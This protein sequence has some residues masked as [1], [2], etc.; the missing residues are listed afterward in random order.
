MQTRSW[1]GWQSA[2]AFCAEADGAAPMAAN[3]MI[4]SDPALARLI[5]FL[6]GPAMTL[7][8]LARS[9]RARR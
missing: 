6:A 3:A 1:Y 8:S 2:A 7:S 4:A 9:L 5:A